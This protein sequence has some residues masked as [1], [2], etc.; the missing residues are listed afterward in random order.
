MHNGSSSKYCVCGGGG[1][2]ISVSRP[3]SAVGSVT[4]NQ[5]VAGSTPDLAIYFR[6]D[7]S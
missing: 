5:R 4:V 6:G 1:G 2:P 7:Y 3:P